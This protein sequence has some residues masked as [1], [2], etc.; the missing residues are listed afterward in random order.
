MGYWATKY[1]DGIA[2]VSHESIDFQMRKKLDGLASTIGAF[3]SAGDF[4]R[5]AYDKSPIV[6]YIYATFGITVDL[7]RGADIGVSDDLLFA[8]VQPPQLDKNHP[9]VP[10]FQ[11]AMVTADDLLSYTKIAKNNNLMGVV[12]KTNAKIS[13]AFSDILCPMYLSVGLLKNRDFSDLE[14]AAIVAHEIGHVFTYFENFRMT[15]ISNMIVAGATKRLLN[16]ESKVERLK[17]IHDVEKHVGFKLDNHDELAEVT[18][19]DKV[20]IKLVTSVERSRANDMG[21]PAYANRTWERLADDFATRLGAGP[22]LASG[23]YKLHNDS[24]FVFKDS[25][26][27]SYPTHAMMQLAGWWAFQLG[28]V[29]APIS[30]VVVTALLFMSADP[31]YLIY[32]RPKERF[33]SIRNTMVEELKI[34][35]LSGELRKLIVN[36]IA[37][38][39]GILDDVNDKYNMFEL[40]HLYILPSGRKDRKAIQYQQDLERMIAND[41]F[42]SAAKL[43]G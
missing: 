9:L 17:I 33:Q 2:M 22:A 36:D 6:T 27:Y 14:V 13:G 3:R 19:D 41:L 15:T 5:T 7:R 40:V 43:K 31:H 8:A 24:S 30:A 26:F 25:A 16:T 28:T 10:N 35:G 12:D 29:I 11:R 39:D 38:V 32:D 1:K 21:T 4:S 23:L 34:P 42:V 20:F 18:T 37:W